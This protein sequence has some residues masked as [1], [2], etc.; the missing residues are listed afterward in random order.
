MIQADFS[1]GITASGLGGECACKAGETSFWELYALIFLSKV[2]QIVKKK[3]VN[4][5]HSGILFIV[6]LIFTQ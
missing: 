1:V 6:I 5:T 4:T 2:K 3:I